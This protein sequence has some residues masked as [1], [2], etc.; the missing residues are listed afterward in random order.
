M[1][2]TRLD[3]D[4]HPKADTVKERIIEA[5]VRAVA[6]GPL[7]RFVSTRKVRA[8][9]EERFER[10][11]DGKTFDFGPIAKSVLRDPNIGAADVYGSMLEL[12]EN[13]RPQGINVKEPQLDLDVETR[14]R[15]RE[16][17]RRRR[18]AAPLLGELLMRQRLIFDWQLQQGL[19][20][21]ASFGGRLGSHLVKLGYLNEAALAHFLGLQKNSPAIAPNILKSTP[22]ETLRSMPSD[23]A[24]KH[25]A[26]AVGVKGGAVKVAMVDPT[27]K[28]AVEEISRRTG[29]KILP[30]IAPE[31]SID[32]LIADYLGVRESK[33]RSI[34]VAGL[35]LGGAEDFQVVHTS[36]RR[37][38][39]PSEEKSTNDGAAITVEDRGEFFQAERADLVTDDRSIADLSLDLTRA[40]D[41]TA[42]LRVA[43][44]MLS[45]RFERVVAFAILDGVVS[46]SAQI[47][48]A[49]AEQ[50]LRQIAL[51]SKDS[52]IFS[53]LSRDRRVASGP[54]RPSAMD[55]ALL[56]SL[57]VEQDAALARIAVLHGDRRAGVLLAASPKD[58]GTL[59]DAVFLQRIAQKTSLALSLIELR[60]HILAA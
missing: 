31:I 50:E 9:I 5:A 53:D 26:L 45:S 48:C 27:D 24:K 54:C 51:S 6:D 12:I 37:E 22:Q 56:S 21:Q 52:T 44:K 38:K 20:A 8:A 59:R 2:L 10:F 13:L 25:K 49:I 36:R 47:G 33:P 19:R 30:V 1:H 18:G 55:T 23:L 39:K 41:L 16:E 29:W 15:I 32:A 58:A 17:V 35:D 14:D 3:V 34:S 42:V 7:S 40:I 11:F 60:T 43:A 4:H 28:S 57:G 46:G